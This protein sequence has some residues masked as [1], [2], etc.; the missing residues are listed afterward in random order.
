MWAKE[1]RIPAAI[2]FGAYLMMQ[3]KKAIF[4]DDSL[5][6]AVAAAIWIISAGAIQRQLRYNPTQMH[7]KLT[8]ISALLTAAG[9]CYFW[10]RV[11]G[12]PR[13]FGSLPFLISD[14]AVIAAMLIIGR[15]I[16]AVIINRI[17]VLD[18]ALFGRGSGVGSVNNSMRPAGHAKV[19]ANER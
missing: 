18:G 5:A 17:R 3:A 1:W 13:E 16:G 15:E 12:A 8:G 4:S 9:L 7:R 14:L 19:T 6:F 2:V 10:A 11:T